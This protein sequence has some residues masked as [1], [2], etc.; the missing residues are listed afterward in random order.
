VILQGE[1]ISQTIDGCRPHQRRRASRST[2]V[3]S[4]CGCWRTTRLNAAERSWVQDK[5]GVQHWIV[6][7]KA[8]YDIA[9]TD[10]LNWRRRKSPAVRL[11]VHRGDPA[12][13]ALSMMP[14]SSDEKWQPTFSWTEQPTRAPQTGAVSRG[15]RQSRELNKMLRVTGDRQWR[16]SAVVRGDDESGAVRVDA[17]D[18]RARVLA[19]STRTDEDRRAAPVYDT[20][21]VGTGFATQAKPERKGGAKTSNIRRSWCALE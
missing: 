8:T 15:R 18:L 13:R 19:A 11:G 14:T 1:Y 2:E 17:A 16:T 20:N 3:S 21:P 12:R 9:R 6:V 7:V 5:N 10:R 4:L